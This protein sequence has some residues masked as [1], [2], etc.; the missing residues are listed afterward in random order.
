MSDEIEQLVDNL[1]SASRGDGIEFVAAGDTVDSAAEVAAARAGLLS[2]VAALRSERDDARERHETASRELRILGVVND[3][4]RAEN[5][6][7]RIELHDAVAE[8]NAATDTLM[9][10]GFVRCDIAACNCG[11]WHPRYGLQERFNE[12]KQ[13]LDDA[14]HPLSNANGNRP[15]NA[16]MA[17]IA[18]RDE[19]EKALRGVLKWVED[20]S[21][22][23]A[24]CPTHFHEVAGVWDDDAGALLAVWDDDAGALLAGNPCA[25]CAAW[26]AARAALEHKNG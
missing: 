2:A 22:S 17:L 23:A 1:S 20:E 14:G 9:A 26:D 16:L 15:L 5:E 4:L 7:L 25:D 19:Y 10:H 6:R 13:A 24:G 18:E 21:G 8:R 12:F 11:R 3:S